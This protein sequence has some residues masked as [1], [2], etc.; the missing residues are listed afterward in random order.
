VGTESGSRVLLV[1]VEERVRAAQ[2][3]DPA[4]MDALL[5]ELEPWL[6]P[7]CGSIALDRGDDALQETMV[8][9]LRNLV[10]LREP[11]AMRAWARRIAV[12]ESIRIV[13]GQREVVMDVVH[14][15]PD[16][17][18]DIAAAVDV[19][20]TLASLPP[21]HRAVLVLRHLEDLSEA[22]VADALD[23]PPGTV[24]SRLSRAKAAFASRWPR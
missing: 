8:I 21:E 4:A 9:I 20:A 5:G 22:E 12:R 13:R 11:A 23:V 17:L 24:K 6:G 3:G 15:V 2:R 10:T 18:P 14:E 7:I 19:R 1:P 16:E